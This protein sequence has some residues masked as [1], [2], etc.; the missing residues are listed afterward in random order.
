[1]LHEILD[2]VDKKGIYL[3]DCSEGHD[4]PGLA[5]DCVWCRLADY[6][7]ELEAVK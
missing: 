4:A 5:E 7:K 3:P 1:L 6:L 2:V